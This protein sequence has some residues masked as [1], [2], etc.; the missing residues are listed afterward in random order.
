MNRLA[1]PTMRFWHDFAD[2]VVDAAARAAGDLHL[3]DCAVCRDALRDLRRV[4][5]HLGAWRADDGGDGLLQRTIAAALAEA[6]RTEAPASSP[7]RNRVAKSVVLGSALVVIGVV[8]LVV[9]RRLD[10]SADHGATQ[11][12]GRSQETPPPADAP[13]PPPVPARSVASPVFFAAA[14]RPNFDSTVTFAE[15]LER[16]ISG[17]ARAD[18][19]IRRVESLLR[20]APPDDSAYVPALER[21]LAAAG[22]RAESA[23]HRALRNRPA[24]F[25]AARSLYLRMTGVEATRAL[26]RLAAERPEDVAL[27][28]DLRSRPLALDEARAHLRATPRAEAFGARCLVA[29]LGGAEVADDLA[30][31]MRRRES[32]TL[33]AAAL[34]ALGTP[35]ALLHVAK[36]LPGPEEFDF[37]I[38]DPE[39]AA[40]EVVVRS[41]PEVGVRAVAAAQAATRMS[42]RRRFYVLA[43]LA[44]DVAVRPALE[45]ALQRNDERAA[46][47]TALRLLRDGEAAPALVGAWRTCRDRAQRRRVFEAVVDLSGPT[48]AVALGSMLEFPEVRAGVLIALGE[49]P[50]ATA[51]VFRALAYADV[52]P[53]AAAILRERFGASSPKVDDPAV[54]ARFRKGVESK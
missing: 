41:V 50:E 45:E 27:T 51:Q 47:V 10:P 24:D 5:R 12:V 30:A 32:K 33:A 9:V 20:D 28:G 39:S 2:D 26:V 14:S 25:A 29:R 53:A 34:A 52:R 38:R 16:A 44:G 31:D 49:R 40:V 19:V 8:A 15:R 42:E 35:D 54:W 7:A 6:A 1:C 13:L 46:A 36:L 48:A 18:D 43:G 17:S 4:D 23:V 11:A 22:T 3:A 21:L 37:G